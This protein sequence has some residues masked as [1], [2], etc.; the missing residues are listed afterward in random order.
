MSEFQR[1]KSKAT[2][3]EY[4]ARRPNPDKVDVL[5]KRAVDAAGRPL[6]AKPKTSVAAKA[7]AKNTPTNGTEPATTPEEGSA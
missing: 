5:D 2:G 3:H 1:V 4:T 7:K 6:R